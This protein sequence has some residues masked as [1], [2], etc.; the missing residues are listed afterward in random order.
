MRH[1]PS[2]NDKTDV[3]ATHLMLINFNETG[4]CNIHLIF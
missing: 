3:Q 1:Y 2:Q 4:S